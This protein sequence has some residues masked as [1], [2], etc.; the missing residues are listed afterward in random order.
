[1]NEE[2]VQTIDA[3]IPK[4]LDEVIRKNRNLVEWG[5]SIADDIQ[6]LRAE[7]QPGLPVKD[8]LD[9]WRIISLREK[10]S[11]LA[12]LLPKIK[13]RMGQFFHREDRLDSKLHRD[14]KWVTLRI[15]LAG[16]W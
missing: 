13:Y 16:H 15:G 3:L 14:E 11:G 10:Q 2:L 4:T 6:A 9:D 8:I 1:M 7:I 5:L 12:Q